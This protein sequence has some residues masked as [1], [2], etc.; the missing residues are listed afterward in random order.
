[1]INMLLFVVRK[2]GGWEGLIRRSLASRSSDGQFAHTQQARAAQ[3]SSCFLHPEREFMHAMRSWLISISGS[4]ARIGPIGRGAGVGA[5]VFFVT[6]GNNMAAVPSAPI[7]TPRHNATTTRNW[8]LRGGLEITTSGIAP[9]IVR[10][11]SDSGSES[12]SVRVVKQSGLK[13]GGEFMTKR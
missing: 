10:T 1:M 3:P 12:V 8:F 7:S 4:V 9:Y 11:L 6:T 2:G 5:S 13:D